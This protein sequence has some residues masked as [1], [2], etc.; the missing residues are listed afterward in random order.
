MREP[1]LFRCE[2][3]CVCVRLS[4]TTNIADTTCAVTAVTN[5]LDSFQ[6]S[7]TSVFIPELCSVMLL[8]PLISFPS[9]QIEYFHVVSRF[10]LLLSIIFTVT[11]IIADDDVHTHS[12]LAALTSPDDVSIFVC[13]WKEKTKKKLLHSGKKMWYQE[14]CGIY[15][16]ITIDKSKLSKV[17]RNLLQKQGKKI[18]L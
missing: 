13:L 15:I 1:F 18:N 2:C 9:Q 14:K 5:K 10:F 3:V 12:S 16:P 7:M 6:N 4:A 8:R 11:S 17:I